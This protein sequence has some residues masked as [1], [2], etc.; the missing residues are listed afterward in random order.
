MQLGL[1]AASI[2]RFTH[3]VLR[4]RTSAVELNPSVIDACRMWFRLPAESARFQVLEMDAARYVSDI[5]RAAS[6]Q[7]LCVDLY[8]HDAASPVLDDAAFY[9]ACHRLLDAGGVMSV[10]LFGRDASFPR[11]AARIAAAFGAAN[12]WSLRP[13]REGNTVVVAGKDV[14]LART[15]RARRAGG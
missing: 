11:S 10:N 5:E 1:G 13:T 14:A 8:D 9:A 12:V 7:V 3:G 4:M 15:R 6:A 2:T